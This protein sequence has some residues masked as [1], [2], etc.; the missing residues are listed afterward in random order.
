MTGLGVVVGCMY[1][2]SC[3]VVY[4][5]KRNNSGAVG[6][7]LALG[8]SEMRQDLLYQSFEPFDIVQATP[9]HN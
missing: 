9:F 4:T 8:R 1:L 2:L 3:L 5:G 7:T 6:R